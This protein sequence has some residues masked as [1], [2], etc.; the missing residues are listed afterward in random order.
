[1]YGFLIAVESGAGIGG[2]Q[3]RAGEKPAIWIGVD[4]TKPE[5]E[6]LGA[7]EGEGAQAGTLLVDWKADDPFLAPD[8]VTLLYSEHA[9][10]PFIRIAAGLENS[11]HYA[12]E[13]DG[14]LPELIYLRL[15]VRDEA[16]NVTTVDAPKAVSVQRTQPQGRVQTGTRDNW[17]P[18]GKS[19]KQHPPEARRPATTRNHRT[20][21]RERRAFDAIE[22]PNHERPLE[23]RLRFPPQLIALEN[24]C[25]G[26]SIPVRIT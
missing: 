7:S 3:P 1:M 12:W 15:E 11:G 20:A 4:K 19:H 10:G 23:A 22:S 16:G 8:A 17:K 5:V 6:L 13:P 2:E 24:P 9:G 18:E 14:A 21:R 25:F 26:L